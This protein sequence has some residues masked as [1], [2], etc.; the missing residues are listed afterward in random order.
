MDYN[1]IKGHEK[2]SIKAKEIFKRTYERHYECLGMEARKAF[3][4]VKITEHKKHLKV[5][6]ANGEWLHYTPSGTWY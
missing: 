2:L 3:V 4:P 1:K 6:F 5:Y